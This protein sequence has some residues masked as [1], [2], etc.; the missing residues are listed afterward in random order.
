MRFRREIKV[1]R[2]YDEEEY[3][4]LSFLFSYYFCSNGKC[5]IAQSCKNWQDDE[6]VLHPVNQTLRVFICLLTRLQEHTHTHLC[7]KETLIPITWHHI[8]RQII[9]RTWLVGVYSVCSAENERCSPWLC[10]SHIISNYRNRVRI[11]STKKPG[12]TKGTRR[13]EEKTTFTLMDADRGDYY[14]PCNQ[15]SARK[16]GKTNITATHFDRTH[17]FQQTIE[18]PFL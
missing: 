6:S 8:K 14:F 5:V 4:F 12:L 16:R 9:H 3:Y 2:I 13:R 18:F 15:I 1:W 11:M 10:Y 17:F 7:N